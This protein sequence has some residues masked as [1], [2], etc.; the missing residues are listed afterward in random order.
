MYAPAAAPQPPAFGKGPGGF[1]LGWIYA[2]Q[3]VE[4]WPENW[5]S[6]ELFMQLGTQWRV[7]PAGVTGLDYAAAYPL[8]DRAHCGDEW[9]AA[10]TDLRVMEAAALDQIRSNAH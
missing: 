2:A 7:G 8:L 3:G 9:D 5:P 1:D 6:L 10:F 4:V